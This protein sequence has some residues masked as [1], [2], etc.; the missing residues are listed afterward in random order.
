MGQVLKERKNASPL[1]LYPQRRGGEVFYFHS[2]NSQVQKLKWK[3]TILGEGGKN[4]DLAL[5]WSNSGRH[6]WLIKLSFK[7]ESNCKE[8]LYKYA[9]KMYNAP[10]EDCFSTCCLRFSFSLFLPGS[11]D[12]SSGLLFFLLIGISSSSSG[13]KLSKLR[14]RLPRPPSSE[15]HNVHQ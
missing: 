4:L 10:S 7:T 8:I 3:S 5:Q 14:V 15:N 11:A 1:A 9:Y 13:S 12:S 2:E 6:K